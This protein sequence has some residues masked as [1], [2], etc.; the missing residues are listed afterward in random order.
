MLSE[1]PH[2]VQVGGASGDTVALSDKLIPRAPVWSILLFRHTVVFL[3]QP[4][5]MAEGAVF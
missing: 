3:G 2:V 5:A 1:C 4:V